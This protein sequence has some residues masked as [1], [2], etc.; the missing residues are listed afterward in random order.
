VVDLV[1]LQHGPFVHVPAEQLEAG[2]AP[3]VGD[4]GAGAGE[5][6]VHA[7]DFVSVGDQAVA[8]VGSEEAS[9]AGDQDAFHGWVLSGAV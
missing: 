2:R 3:E 5:E 8:Q 6:V 9:A 1:D 7:D 4:V